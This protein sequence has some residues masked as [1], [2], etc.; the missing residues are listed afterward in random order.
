MK[1]PKDIWEA[2]EE[3]FAP[4]EEDDRYTEEDD[5]KQWMI[6]E[7]YSNPTDWFNCIDEVNTKISNIDGGK[8]IKNEDDIQP[9]IR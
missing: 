5:I 3:E 6:E 9:Q 4:T 1:N 7:N 2:L 8:Y